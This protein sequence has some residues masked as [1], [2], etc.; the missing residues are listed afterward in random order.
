ME[1]KKYMKMKEYDNILE[2]M[3]DYSTKKYYPLFY[4]LYN[5]Y[6]LIYNNLFIRFFNNK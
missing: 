3:E 1:L 5:F 2:L 4:L 6:V